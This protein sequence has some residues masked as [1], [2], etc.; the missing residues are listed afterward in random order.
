M[1]NYWSSTLAPRHLFKRAYESPELAAHIRDN[2]FVDPAILAA[3]LRVEHLNPQAVEAYQRR[4][5]VRAI[6]ENNPRGAR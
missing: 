4:L 2:S 1:T 5:G 3:D 6:A